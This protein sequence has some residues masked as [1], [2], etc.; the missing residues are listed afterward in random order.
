MLVILFSLGLCAAALGIGMV[1][2]LWW[3]GE[4]LR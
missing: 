1:L 2:G 4:K 3:A